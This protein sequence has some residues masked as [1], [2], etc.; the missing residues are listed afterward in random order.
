M[1]ATLY[2]LWPNLEALNIKGQAAA[3]NIIPFSLQATATAYGLLYAAALIVCA[4]LIFQRRD[5]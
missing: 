5:F 1:A 3:G 2:Y 4:C